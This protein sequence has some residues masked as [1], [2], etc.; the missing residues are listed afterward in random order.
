MRDSAARIKQQAVAIITTVAI[1]VTSW[2][3]PNVAILFQQHCA[4]TMTQDQC[5]CVIFT[6]HCFIWWAVLMWT[7]D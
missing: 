6:V 3:I 1:A 4:P 5:E 7:Y 2:M